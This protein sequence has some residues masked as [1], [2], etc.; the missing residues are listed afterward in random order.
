[1]TATVLKLWTVGKSL[2]VG[3]QLKF[4]RVIQ[5]L[6][7]GLFCNEKAELSIYYTVTHQRTAYE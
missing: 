5:G 4:Y 7:K 3:Q 6:S 2:Y 1:M